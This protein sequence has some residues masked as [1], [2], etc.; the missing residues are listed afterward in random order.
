[1]V[2]FDRWDGCHLYSGVY[3]MEIS[4]R[5]KESLRPYQDQAILIDA[6]KVEQPMNPG[7]GLITRLNVLGPAKE[8]PRTAFGPPD[9]EGLT[10]S[11]VPDFSTGGPD[12]LIIELRNNTDRRREIDMGALAPTLL[13]QKDELECFNP[14]DGPSYTAVTRASLRTMQDQAVGRSCG[15]DGKSRTAKFF[16][17]PGI[18]LASRVKLGPGQSLEI[19]LRFQLSAGEYEFMSGYGGGVHA[20]RTLASNRFGFDVDETG[21]AHLLKRAATPVARTTRRTGSVCGT[22]S[23]ED[24]SRA[25]KARVFLWPLPMARREPRA[26][27]SELTDG[28]G[29]FQLESVQEGTY[30]LSAMY[31][32]T[33]GIMVGAFGGTR[34]SDAAAL[35]V[36]DSA[37]G[38]SLSVTLHRQPGYTVKGRT[39]AGGAEQRKV[40]MILTSGDAY[41]FESTAEVQ[42]DGRYEFHNVPPGDYQF[43]AGWTGWGYEITSDTEDNVD[44]KWPDAAEEQ[45][46]APSKEVERDAESDETMTIFTLEELRRELRAYADTYP[47]GFAPNLKAL[48]PPPKWYRTTADYAGLIDEWKAA[49]IAPDGTQFSDYGYSVTYHPGPTDDKGKITTY[50]LSA[51]PVEF[52]KTGARSFFLDEEGIVHATAADGPATRSDPALKN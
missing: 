6:L 37:E 14:A 33:A 23:L 52:G 4:E 16:M 48:G 24:G 29:R 21:R 32:N 2:V 28:E 47:R 11:V 17:A 41:P 36:P 7:D 3:V 51:R 25:A 5:I 45:S 20:G 19:P 34:P 12:E 1:V 49:K 26:A 10:L 35:A 42:P 27:Y 13:A 40:R 9:L 46:M 8:E 44:I 39:Q 43:F 31:S 30:V 22:V 50:T 38:C 15:M 18:S